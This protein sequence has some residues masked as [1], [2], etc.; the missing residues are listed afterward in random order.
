VLDTSRVSPSPS[1]NVALQIEQECS[2]DM[3]DT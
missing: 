3:R 1:A 2:G